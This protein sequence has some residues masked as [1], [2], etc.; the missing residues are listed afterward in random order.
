MRSHDSDL[1]IRSSN[2]YNI[3]FDIN[4]PQT[5]TYIQERD[6]VNKNLSITR[7]SSEQSLQLS[8]VRESITT[9]AL[10]NRFGQKTVS[11]EYF[12]H[13]LPHK[14]HKKFYQ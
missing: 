13:M 10:H 4:G 8:N 11:K 7:Q 12:D 6:E 3:Y 5:M 14:K 1:L 2:H 9:H